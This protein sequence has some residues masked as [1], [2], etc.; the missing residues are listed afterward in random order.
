MIAESMRK[1]AG[2]VLVAGFPGRAAPVE[3][4]EAA[5]RGEL[6]GFVL[7]KRNLGSAAEV[8]ELTAGL[9]AAFPQHAPPF[10][11]V[12][13]E[14]GRVQRLGAPVLQLPPMRALGALDD[15]ELTQALA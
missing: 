3:L 2:Q 13:Q 12:D 8:A 9:A 15:P 6:G 5:G 10:V 1:A 7:F 14:G 4:L 11:A